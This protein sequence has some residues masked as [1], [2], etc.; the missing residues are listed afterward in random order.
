MRNQLEMVLKRRNNTDK[1]T[2]NEKKKKIVRRRNIRDKLI[3]KQ[4]TKNL[5]EMLYG[6]AGIKQ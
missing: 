1:Y 5:L 2:S 3:Y 4:L 6:G